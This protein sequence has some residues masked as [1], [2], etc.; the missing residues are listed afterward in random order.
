MS[1]PTRPFRY[2]S[3]LLRYWQEGGQDPADAWRFMLED[4]R[5]S[6]RRGFGSLEALVA[7]LE[8]EVDE[9]SEKS[10]SEQPE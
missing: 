9:K 8:K 5:T 7:F 6:K 4:P 3:Y 2:H 1:L 10:A